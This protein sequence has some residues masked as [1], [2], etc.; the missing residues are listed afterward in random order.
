MAKII[1]GGDFRAKETSNLRFS[2]ELVKVLKSADLRVCNFEAPVEGNSPKALKAGPSIDQK[3][4]TAQ[5]LIDNG[6]EVILLANNHVMDFDEAGLFRTKIAFDSVTTVGAGDAKEAY[7]MKVVNVGGKRIGFLSLVQYEFGVL[8][9]VDSEGYGAAWVNS[10]D[11]RDIIEEGNK[12]V[13][14]LIVC[15]HAGIECVDAP[16]PEWRKVYRS[17]IKW[18][19]DAVVASHPHTPQGWEIYDGHYIFY[20]L[21]NFF[22]DGLDYGKHWHESLLVELVI[23][24]KVSAKVYNVRFSG[25][26]ISIDDREETKNHTSYL[27]DLLQNEDAYKIFIDKLCDEL[28]YPCCYRYLRGF[29]GASLRM[30]FKHFVRLF[31]AMIL[32]R[33]DELLLLNAIRCESHRW[34]VERYIRNH[35]K[36]Y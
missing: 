35:Y 8:S 23:D 34:L 10:P 18:G 33:Q 36:V 5:F 30:G 25:N 15:P 12:T 24:D 4:E 9:G 13:D 22:F 11:I 21:G 14:C 20:S 16:L 28:Y 31:G 17:F 7:S 19:A 2:E 3:A 1:I 29:G 6:F 27:L 32:R 26:T